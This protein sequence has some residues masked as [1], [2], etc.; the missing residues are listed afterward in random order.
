MPDLMARA[1]EFIAGKLAAELSRP[2]A[3]SR[4]SD[5]VAITASVGRSSFDVDDGHGMLRFETR[6]YIVRMDA[7]VL[8]GIATLP[9]RGDRITEAS[10]AGD[11]A[12]EVIAVGTTVYWAS[13]TSTATATATSNKLIGKV[14]K[15]AADADATVLVK[16]FQ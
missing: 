2:V 9:R 4:G 12:Y 5:S 14:V 7:L 6:D 3:Y 8:G 16:L 13:G 10:T 1:A 11:V 15:T